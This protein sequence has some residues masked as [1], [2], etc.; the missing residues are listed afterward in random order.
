MHAH[1]AVP[2]PL[3]RQCQARRPGLVEHAAG[4]NR[5]DAVALMA[6]VGFD[7]E[8]GTVG[9]PLHMAAVHGHLEMVEL[10]VGRGVDVSAMDREG[11]TARDWAEWRGEVKCKVYL[12]NCNP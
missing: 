3:P 11:R 12:S 9:T 4:A 1:P 5:L 2:G 6:D 10:L 7:L 8:R